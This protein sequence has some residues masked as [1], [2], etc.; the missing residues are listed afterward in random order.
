MPDE[1]ATNGRKSGDEALAELRD[2]L[3]GP[4]R[5]KIRQLQQR[6]DDRAA[7]AEEISRTL[8]DAIRLQSVRGH[9]LRVA[10]QPILEDSVRISVQRNPKILSDALFP[11]ISE[12]VRKA[13]FAALQTMLQTLN[14]TLEQ[15]VSAR[16]FRWRLEAMRTGKSFA[17]I[18]VLR[19]L[20]YRVEQ[21]FLIHR[22]TGLLLAHSEA[23]SVVVKDADLVSGMLTAI[24]DFM[25]DSFEGSHGQDLETVE[26]GDRTLWIQ[27][28][29]QAIL[30]AVVRGTPPKTL[31]NVLQAAL[32]RICAERGAEM[33][34]FNGNVAPF[35][36]SQKHL[37]ACLVGQASKPNQGQ[38]V[39]LWLVPSAIA[40]A[41]AFWSFVS[42][43]E[44][45]EWK[46]YVQ[47]LSRQ[48]GI[49]I[50][51]AE[52]RGGEYF[53]AGLRDPQ[54]QDPTELLAGTRLPAGK[55]KFALR[56]YLSLE[57]RFAEP[58]EL[59]AAK[60]SVESRKVHF[61]PDRAEIALEQLDSVEGAAA[62]INALLQRYEK[63]GQSMRIEVIG[64]T[65]D[66]GPESR[67]AELS[68]QRANETL[69]SLSAAG[70]PRERLFTRGAGT[71]D[72]LS[73]GTSER[74]RA[75]NRSVS[76]RVVPVAP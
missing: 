5:E 69:A 34:E 29:P 46:Q 32:E 66:S 48:P 64:H 18:V 10:L 53:I 41:A 20:L 27:Y 1:L 57:K 37:K 71:T 16:S 72:P 49:V 39:L 73:K 33:T 26:I 40:L 23:D 47:K 59:A 45:R 60:K 3:V 9:K 30:A 65:D 44:A 50:T 2:I 17:E 67:N 7:R 13:V 76:F 62:D 19:S 15:S 12:T 75:F 8:P 43:R 70:V 38:S 22:K 58:R 11:L 54:A 25:R 74:D 31:K 63:A 24:Q 28:G 35:Q 52:K 21:V 14:Q 61:K 68:Q 51:S 56:D 36:S 55:V 42:I 4:E 6:L